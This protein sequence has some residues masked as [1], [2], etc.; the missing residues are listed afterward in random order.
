MKAIVT[1]IGVLLTGYGLLAS[2]PVEQSGATPEGFLRE[3]ASEL[4]E[5]SADDMTAFYKDSKDTLAIQ[6]TGRMRKGT[7][8]I[9][10]EY[11]A[12]F[13][14]VIFE[15]VTLGDLTVR[16]IGDVAWTTCRF[17]A[18]TLHKVQNTKWTLQVYTSFVL[19]RSGKTWKIVLE[20]STPIAGV[21]RVMPRE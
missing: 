5:G 7:A 3:W 6:L 9:R 16:Q 13:K 4:S 20:Q 10:K 18:L 2:A 1:T 14:E 15:R 8:E 21:S 12:A 17:K 19:K 11:Q